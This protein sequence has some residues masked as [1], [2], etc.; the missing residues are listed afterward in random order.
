MMG[1]Q[2]IWNGQSTEKSAGWKIPQKKTCGKT[3]TEMGGHHE[4]TSLCC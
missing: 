4:A 3:A 1:W 2:H